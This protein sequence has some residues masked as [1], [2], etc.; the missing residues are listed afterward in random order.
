MENDVKRIDGLDRYFYDWLQEMVDF[1]TPG[2]T[3]KCSRTL[4]S[5]SAICL[6]HNNLQTGTVYY[7]SVIAYNATGE[8]EMSDV[9]QCHTLSASQTKLPGIQSLLY[10]GGQYHII[11]V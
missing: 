6:M 4:P 1:K 11:L 7:F 8:S 10:N 3:R 2:E 5:E 9:I